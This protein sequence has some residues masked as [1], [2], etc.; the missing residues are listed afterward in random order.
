MPDAS[1]HPCEPWEHIVAV[2]E[3]PWLLEIKDK[4]YSLSRCWD[5]A[6]D[7]PIRLC[8]ARMGLIKVCYNLIDADF[9][10]PEQLVALQE[11]YRLHQ[12]TVD[13]EFI[14]GIRL[15]LELRL[16][17]KLRSPDR[18]NGLASMG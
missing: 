9:I 16:F 14:G 7:E 1:W 3:I 11:L 15:Q 10:T 12:P 6:D 18:L 4:H 8:L 13:L 17:L 5:L 2:K